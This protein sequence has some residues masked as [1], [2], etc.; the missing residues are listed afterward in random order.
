MVPPDVL[1][2]ALLTLLFGGI[3]ISDVL[4]CGVGHRAQTSLCVIGI[5]QVRAVRLRDLGHI[6]GVVIGYVRLGLA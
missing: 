1:V 5:L 3:A 2:T 4:A 6:A